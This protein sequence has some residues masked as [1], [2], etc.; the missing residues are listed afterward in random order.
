MCQLSDLLITRTLPDNKDSQPSIQTN[1]LI[2]SCQPLV[3]QPKLSTA[4]QNMPSSALCGSRGM[5][6]KTSF[7]FSKVASNAGKS[8]D[9]IF[10]LPNG[11][12]VSLTLTN[13][14]SHPCTTVK[15]NIAEGASK[16]QTCQT[17]CQ[18]FVGR[19]RC[20]I[21]VLRLCHT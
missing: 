6:V 7:S 14:S 21:T 9:Y 3:P 4:C 19:P 12:L 5:R 10:V 11:L 18:D 1:H 17:F 2:R 20:R 15:K 13:H 8:S 16:I